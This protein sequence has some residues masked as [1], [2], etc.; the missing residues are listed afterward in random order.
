MSSIAILGAGRVG[1]SLARAALAAGDDVTVA[2]S[3]DPAR[4]R[5]IVEML[6][7]G[8]RAETA[9]DAV[10]GADLVVLA[11][12]M[13][14][15]RTVDPAIL[16]GKAVIDLMNQWEPVDGP[17]PELDAAVDGSST[18]VQRH[19]AGA[20]IVKTLNQ[21]GYHELEEDARAAGHQRRRALGVAGDDADAVALAS[22]FVERI[23][24][25]AV[26]IGPLAAGVALQPGGPVFG[27]FHDAAALAAAV[28]RVAA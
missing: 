22:A 6:A 9:A 4:I 8:A 12:P 18:I 25:D 3:G 16:A 27:V 17:L 5:L 1:T 19:F 21:L 15:F 7:P 10:A 14:E 28:E 23:G 26:P 20:R 2:A 11:V 13:H 24:F